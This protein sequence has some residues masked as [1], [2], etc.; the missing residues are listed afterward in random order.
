MGETFPNHNDDSYPR[1]NLGAK[2]PQPM[3]Q[4]VPVRPGAWGW[5]DLGTQWEYI[6][7]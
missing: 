4:A 6:E 3:A 7:F 1:C 2:E 5:K